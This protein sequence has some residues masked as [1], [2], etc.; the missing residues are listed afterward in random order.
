MYNQTR[1]QLVE[2][3]DTTLEGLQQAGTLSLD[4]LQLILHDGGDALNAIDGCLKDGLSEQ[5]YRTY[6][7]CFDTIAALYENLHQDAEPS[8]FSS[9]A[10]ELQS[11]IQKLKQALLDD[12]TIRYEVCF[13]PYKASMWD[14]FDTIWEAAIADPL[15]D[16]YVVPIP[17]YERTPNG[18][19]GK[20]CYEGSLF[21]AHIPITNYEEYDLAL[22]H[23]DLLYFLNPYDDT[24]KVTSIAPDYYSSRLKK[25]TDMLVYV[26]YFFSAS[27]T[28][29]P[30]A[31]IFCGGAKA[32]RNADKVIVQ[33]ERHKELYLS[34][35]CG[36]NK[37]LPLGSPKLDKL[38][39]LDA[40]DTSL[41][42]EWAS[43]LQGREKVFLFTTTLVS[44]VN[45]N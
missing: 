12:P 36:A 5:Q 26:P 28:S 42:D 25:H 18:G 14:S 40:S 32:I 39:Q 17:Y 43:M 16:V 3:L 34:C 21:P 2:L 30:I 31:C 27:F 8:A 4:A 9:A 22:R 1:K 38:A 19:F 41:P 33:S 24:N 6:D 35:G 23:P 13:M 10:Q 29:K 20:L 44:C 11:P 45:Y 7:D 15:C 37:I